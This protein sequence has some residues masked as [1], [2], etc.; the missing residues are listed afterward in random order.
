[1]INAAAGGTVRQPHRRPDRALKCWGRVVD[2]MLVK[3]PVSVK[4]A[5]G[6]KPKRV[7][8]DQKKLPQVFIG[9]REIYAWDESIGTGRTVDPYERS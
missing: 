3:E 1:M 5:L 7:Y 9:G 4:N 2:E 8:G 6:E